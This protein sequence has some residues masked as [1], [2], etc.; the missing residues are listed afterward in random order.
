MMLVGSNPC[1]ELM[2]LIVEQE[3]GVTV[4]AG[5]PGVLTHWHQAATGGVVLFVINRDASPRRV[6]VTL[7]LTRAGLSPTARYRVLDEAGDTRTLF[8]RRLAAPDIALL[9]YA[10]AWQKIEPLRFADK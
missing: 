3:G 5:E 2:R 6:P 9:G 4:S 7:G 1:P 10:V 8:G